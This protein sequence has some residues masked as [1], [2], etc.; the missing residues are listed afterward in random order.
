MDYH[1]ATC[2]SQVVYNFRFTLKT[3]IGYVWAYKN[4]VYFRRMAY[5]WFF[6]MHVPTGVD[7]NRFLII[8]R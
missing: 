8:N 6:P 4:Q 7:L 3:I 5:I 2:V 1:D